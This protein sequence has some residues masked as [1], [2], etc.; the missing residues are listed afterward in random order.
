LRRSHVHP[1]AAGRLV[2]ERKA[3]AEDAG[4]KPDSETNEVRL[5]PIAF[6]HDPTSWGVGRA[7]WSVRRQREAP[8]EDAGAGSGSETNEAP[9]AFEHDKQKRLFKLTVGGGQIR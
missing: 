5:T 6:E 7:A 1:D 3:P 4:T 2:D 8:A 9:I